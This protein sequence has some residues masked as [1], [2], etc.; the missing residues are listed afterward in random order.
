MRAGNGLV[1][2]LLSSTIFPYQ[3]NINGDEEKVK[4]E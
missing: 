4:Q 2:D 1:V 3:K